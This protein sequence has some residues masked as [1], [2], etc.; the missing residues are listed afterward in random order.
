MFRLANVPV[1]ARRVLLR[2]EVRTVVE[3]AVA[4]I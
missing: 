4:G 3:I 1:K 2:P